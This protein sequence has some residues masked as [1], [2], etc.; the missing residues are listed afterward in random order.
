MDKYHQLHK[1]LGKNLSGALPYL[2]KLPDLNIQD[3]NQSRSTEAGSQSTGMSIEAGSQSNEGTRSPA[4]TVSWSL[5][6][7]IYAINST[8]SQAR[9]HY[10]KKSKIYTVTPSRRRICKPLVRKSYNSFAT[11]CVKKNQATK[12]AIVNVMGQVLR[13][14]VAAICSDDFDSIT[15]EKSIDSV[16]SFKNVISSLHGELRSRAPTLLS[17]LMSCLK[18]AK[19]RRNTTY[20]VAVILSIVC[21]HRRTSSC[22]IQRIVSL[23][24]YT[25]HASKQVSLFP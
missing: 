4:L 1:Q 16:Q 24:L 17:L 15:R 14:E 12:H 7:L 10:P 6:S 19:P 21:K 2:P 20:I 8:I 3:V 11:Q 13:S 23:V 9:I 25:G 5:N 18:T 22:L